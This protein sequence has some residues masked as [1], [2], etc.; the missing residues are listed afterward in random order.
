MKSLPECA[1]ALTMFTF[2]ACSDGNIGTKTKER[3][4]LTKRPNI[5]LI[6][7]DDLGYT[8]IGAFG[9][10]IPTPNLDRLAREGLRLTNFHTGRACQQTRAMLMASTG[11]TAA[12]EIR[13]RIFP[14]TRSN[15]LKMDWAILPELLQDAGYRTYMAGKWDL[16]FV[17]KYRP[18]VRGFDRSFAMMEG[19]ES[20][21][22]EYFWRESVAY[23][24][25]GR[26]LTL[27]DLPE[28]FYSTR[29]YT[30]KMLEY[31]TS[32]NSEA[33]PWFG[34]LAYTAPHW[35]LQVPDKWLDRHA[36]TYAL[37][38]DTLRG[39]RLEK[40]K[41]EGVLPPGANTSVFE[42]I[43]KP[44]NELN[45]EEQRRYSRSQEI[46]ASMVEYMDTSIGRIVDFLEETNQLDNTLIFFMADHG[47]STLETG[48][49]QGDSFPAQPL[50]RNNEFDNFGKIGSFIDHGI[51]FGEA[52][53]APFK[54]FKGNM[55]EG[56]VRAAAFARYPTANES[57]GVSHVLITALDVMPT[58]LAA[59]G[60]KHP[61]AGEFR[62][63]EIKDIK[64]ISFWP[65]M[66]GQRAPER[67]DRGSI[68]WSNGTDGAL[69]RGDF[70]IINQGKPGS[71][72]ST[73]WRLYNIES[74]PSETTDIRAN[75]PE[76]LGVMIADWEL[77]WK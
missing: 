61:G 60:I 64:G 1:L 55:S 21:F 62:G 17:G 13:P 59:A 69:I 7:A 56:G 46:Y 42:A 8:D 76:V 45:G 38:Y 70:K 39:S 36:G 28:N 12:L 6:V 47:A 44:W 14:G 58:L 33:E 16:G 2:V 49:G 23:E 35:P 65:F 71:S 37:G 57:P 26:R 54:Y 41:L 51:G 43:A 75:H 32:N 74:D 34:Y 24:D 66:N 27:E 29:F 30:D 31:L 10:E 22:A 67:E 40:A 4:N 63:R 18:S 73:P 20:H 77:N 9:S 11:T 3:G 53:S 50:P 19:G 25:E 15:V 68:G 5:L 72:G 48:P 52:A